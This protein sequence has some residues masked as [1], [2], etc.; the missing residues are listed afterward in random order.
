MAAPQ[1]V[2]CSW[3]MEN[4][5]DQNIDD[6]CPSECVVKQMK[7]QATRLNQMTL[8]Q[9]RKFKRLVEVLEVP[10]EKFDAPAK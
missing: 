2:F 5:G 4:F 10:P 1:C 8:V 9:G 3:K 7:K 6:N